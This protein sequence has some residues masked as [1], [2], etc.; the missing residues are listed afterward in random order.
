MSPINALAGAQGLIS[1]A[2]ANISKATGLAN[3]ISNLLNRPG[4][5]F[6]AQL[7]PASFRGVKFGVLSGQARFG[8]RNALH[9]YPFRDKPW[10]EDLGRQS[11][12]IQVAGFLIGDDV[13]AQRD[14]LIAVC[15]KPGDGELIHPTL[16]RMKVAL[17]DVST[18]ENWERGR[19]F[20]INFTFVE[21]GQ[22]LYPGDAVSSKDAIASAAERVKASAIS[23]FVLKLSAV[24]S[25]GNIALQI[26]GTASAW[27]STAIGAVNSATSLMS[28]A[29]SLQ[30][31]FGR[32]LGQASGI[33]FSSVLSG[34]T[35]LE[36][37]IGSGAA[38]RVSVSSAVSLLTAGASGISAST[39]GSFAA[40]GAQLAA[41]VRSASFTPAVALHSMQSMTVVSNVDGG[42]LPQPTTAD[43]FRLVAVCELAKAS[44]DYQP[45]TSDEA[46][47]VRGQALDSI[48]AEITIA[49]NQGDDEVY[50]TLRALRSEVIRDMNA[51][52]AQLPTLITV[53]TRSPVPSLVLAQRLYRDPGR[54]DE[55]ARRA[56]PVHP[57]FM[58]LSFSALSS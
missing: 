9:E 52:G 39:L 21:Q 7:K 57:A 20:E 30:G 31:N 19:V 53:T 54:D 36:A 28:I 37:L 17:I 26:A 32:L 34:V 35:S 22:R 8:R 58:P 41:A 51:K 18:A 47:S 40:L 6:W 43:L 27:A 16:G 46:V 44:G 29:S 3:G 10:V 45:S 38:A 56:N 49:G 14:R 2:G 55:L 48:D 42:A 11:R 12:R 4:A 33:S 50:T 25:V 5:S 24:A 23:A 1:S 13:I 15:E